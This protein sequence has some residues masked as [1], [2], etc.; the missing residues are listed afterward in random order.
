MLLLKQAATLMLWLS[1]L[2]QCC[3]PVFAQQNQTDISFQHL[4]GGLSQSSANVIFEDSYGYLW[5]GT[6]NGLNKYDGKSFE[7]YEQA[8]D[9]TTGLTNGYIEDIYEDDDRQLYIGTVQGLNIYQR[10]MDVLKP[11]PFFGE[12]KKIALE[13]FYSI[14]KSSDILWLGTTTSLFKYHTTTGDL[15]EFVYQEGT[16]N[17]LKNN[18]FVKIAGLDNQNTLVFIDND[19]WLLDKELQIVS[20]FHENQRIRSVIQQNSTQFLIGLHN[21]E[22]LELKIQPDHALKVERKK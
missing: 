18:Y 10:E 2:L 11:Y 19:I 17:I 4:P 20:K 22:L 16:P 15:K 12:G 1:L 21:G 7:I 13:H 14:T 9:S 5:I 8:V 6:R 3:T